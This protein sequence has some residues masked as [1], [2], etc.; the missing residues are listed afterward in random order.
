MTS[1][2]RHRRS[3][4]T[5]V[6]EHELCVHPRG[7]QVRVRRFERARIDV[8][9]VQGSTG[10]EQ[11]ALDQ[12][13]ARTH[14]GI[15]HDVV[16]R[17]P[18]YARERRGKRRVRACRRLVLA[19]GKTRIGERAGQKLDADPRRAFV[20]HHLPRRTRRVVLTSWG[21]RAETVRA[22]RQVSARRWP[23]EAHSKR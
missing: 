23:A 13:A 2:G 8:R 17:N 15:P 18:R 10:P 7:A 1:D 21:K 16:R 20:N 4:A 14:E 6:P 9:S 3:H 5:R 12:L 19:V 22:T 11:S